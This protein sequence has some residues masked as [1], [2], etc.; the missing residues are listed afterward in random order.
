VQ[1]SSGQ[2]TGESL[3]SWAPGSKIERPLEGTTLQGSGMAAKEGADLEEGRDEGL[4]LVE[5][6]MP[7]SIHSMD[8]VSLNE[9]RNSS[10][11]G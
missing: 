9:S 11:S 7:A 10:E 6:R 1:G 2:A 8:F 4:G 5:S 3:R